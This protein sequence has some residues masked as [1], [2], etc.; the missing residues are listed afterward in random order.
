MTQEVAGIDA[1]RAVAQ[2]IF[3]ALC[4]QYPDK[5]IALIQPRDV[6]SEDN[7]AIS[8]TAPSSPL[9]C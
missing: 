4:A 1:R 3:E 5:H 8:S 2:H 7:G 9:P 6:L